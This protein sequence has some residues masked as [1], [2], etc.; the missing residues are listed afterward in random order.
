MSHM[1]DMNLVHHGGPESEAWRWECD[2]MGLDEQKCDVE[3]TFIDG[4]M[5]T[6]GQTT[7]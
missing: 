1:G 2:G 3:M 5:N 4:I 7:V 6:C